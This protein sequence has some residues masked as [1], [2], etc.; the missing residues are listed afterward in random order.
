MGELKFCEMAQT[1][2]PSST[3]L[4]LAPIPNQEFIGWALYREKVYSEEV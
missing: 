1:V 3:V 4:S 2:L